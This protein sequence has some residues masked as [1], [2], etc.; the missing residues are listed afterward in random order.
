LSREKRSPGALLKHKRRNIFRDVWIIWFTNT[1]EELLN[2]FKNDMKIA[3]NR[4]C[5]LVHNG[6]DLKV[7]SVKHIMV[8]LKIPGPFN[9][10]TWFIPEEILNDGNK[11]KVA[12]LQAF[13][14][15]EATVSKSGDV[16]LD[17]VNKKGLLQVR[18]MLTELRILTTF[19]KFSKNVW[20]LRIRNKSLLRFHKL[21]GFVHPDKKQKLK[22]IIME[23]L[24]K[25]LPNI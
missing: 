11:V 18:K 5:T 1:C 14:D 19:N 25:R 23:R 16:K 6:T 2:Q 9:C 12:W 7:N 15:D 24:N 21:V 13:F 4:K 3:F 20:R 10:R 17:V 8:K 22:N